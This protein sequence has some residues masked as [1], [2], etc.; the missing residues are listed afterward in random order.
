MIMIKK[1]KVFMVL[2]LLTSLIVGCNMNPNVSETTLDGTSTTIGNTSITTET[3]ELINYQ[4]IYMDNQEEI[5]PETVNSNYIKAMYGYTNNSIQGYNGWFYQIRS[6]STFT[7]MEFNTENSRWVSDSSYIDGAIQFAQSGSQISKTYLVS[8]DGNVYIS[9]NVKIGDKTYSG[10]SEY[11][12]ALNGNI[13]FP[14]SGNFGIINGDD[15]YGYYVTTE[16]A[17]NTG[18]EIQFISK[19]DGEVYWNPTI[20]YSQRTE[21]DIHFDLTYSSDSGIHIG[22]VHP[23]YYEGRLYMYY[24]ATNGQFNTRLLVSDD[25]VRYQ[26]E[27]L[28]TDMVNPPATDTYYV[29]GVIQHKS[30]IFR[31]Y[32]GFSSS[33]INSSTSDDLITWKE[34]KGVDENFV[35]TYLPLVNYPVGGRDPYVF[36]DPD[37]D[38]YRVIYNGYYENKYWNNGGD[39]MDVGLSIATSTDDTMMYFEEEQFEVLRFTNEGSSGRDEPEVSQMMKIGD[40]WY[41][42]ASVYGRTTNGVGGMSYW[43]G[44]SNTPIEDQDWELI[45]EQ[46]LTGEDLCAAQIVEVGNRYYIFGWIP[47]KTNGSWGGTLNIAR[48]VYV[49]PNGDLATRLDPYL[50]DLLNK[51][52][53]YEMSDDDFAESGH[54]IASDNSITLADGGTSRFGFADEDFSVYNLA[55]QYNRNLITFSLDMSDVTNDYSGVMLDGNGR[56]VYIYIDKTNDTLFIKSKEASGYVVKSKISVAGLDYSDLDFKIIVEG[57]IVDVYINDRVSL[58]AKISDFGYKEL[59]NYSISLYSNGVNSEFIDFNVYQLAT[60]ENIYD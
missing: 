38:R 18:D 8:K 32:F 2:F 43:K 15:T 23:Y 13:I 39:D 52:K 26:E 45:P 58:S 3:Q 4:D 60:M 14:E 44:N 41:L 47:S 28:F 10:T 25:M 49:L 9:A 29:L 35:S 16:I 30:G 7:D 59:Q 33:V 24:L 51:G 1:F 5:Y 50:T 22:D 56:Q 31:S 54:W 36:Y 19:G 6:N 42:F 53:V 27:E 21:S 40:R 57:S 34:G 46:M 55:G 12:I 11:A 37:V 20:E 17:V 48:E